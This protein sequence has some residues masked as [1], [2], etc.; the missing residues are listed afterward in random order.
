MAFKHEAQRPMR[1]LLARL[2]LLPLTARKEIDFEAAEPS[3]LVALL[4][5]AETTMNTINRGVGA[6]GLL[7]AASSHQVADGTICADTIE[8]LG[9]TVRNQR[10]GRRLH[11][12]R[13]PVPT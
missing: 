4:D 5:D 7:L 1:S 9:F 3:L 6:I 2:P 8:S 13:N 11:G 10:H 12:A